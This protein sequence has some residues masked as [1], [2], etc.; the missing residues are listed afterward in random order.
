MAVSTEDGNQ[1]QAASGSNRDDVASGAIGL[2][3]RAWV[4]IGNLPNRLVPG[5]EG[6][7]YSEG[8]PG[9]RRVA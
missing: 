8:P 1:S 9:P 3:P 7:V 2:V 5:L 6:G 4:A